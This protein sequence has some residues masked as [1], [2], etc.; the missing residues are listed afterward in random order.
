MSK[1]K[2]YDSISDIL[3]DFKDAKFSYTGLV[4]NLLFRSKT[5]GIIPIAKIVDHIYDRTRGCVK[6]ETIRA[7]LS[8]AMHNK[9]I[10]PLWL[11]YLFYEV[12]RDLTKA[13]TSKEIRRH[14]YTCRSKNC[15][16]KQF[17]CAECGLEQTAI[18]EEVIEGQLHLEDFI[19]VEIAKFVEE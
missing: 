9:R 11:I 4:V 1:T 6:K 13:L 15:N 5:L 10:P 16:C 17:V 7:D 2:D 19:E 3:D 12:L 14:Q 8:R 18:V